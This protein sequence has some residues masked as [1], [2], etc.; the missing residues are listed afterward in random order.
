MSAEK[1]NAPMDIAA[2]PYCRTAR[3]SASVGLYER[4]VTVNGECDLAY[5][6]GCSVCRARG[7]LLAS[8]RGAIYFWN[9][10][11]R[12]EHSAQKEN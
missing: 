4:Y 11:A 6:V 1:L 10:E 7:P 2:C 5:F 9:R 3:S 12:R 8:E